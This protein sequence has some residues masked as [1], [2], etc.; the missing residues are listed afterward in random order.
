MACAP[1][2][3]YTL[4]LRNQIDGSHAS[5]C[6]QTNNKAVSDGPLAENINML[7]NSFWA[8]FSYIFAPLTDIAI[9]VILVIQVEAVALAM[10]VAVA[11]V[12]FV[13]GCC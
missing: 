10:C 11:M 5:R 7:S 4:D 9:L 3:Q 8:F 6:L 13:F 1:I 2:I 12:V